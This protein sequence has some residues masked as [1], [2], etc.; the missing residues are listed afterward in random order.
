MA[1]RSKAHAWSACVS[2][3]APWVRIPVSP[4]G[5]RSEAE[6]PLYFWANLYPSEAESVG[7]P[8]SPHIIK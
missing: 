6:T 5:F 7:G 4:H 1:E 2:E 3:M 8:H